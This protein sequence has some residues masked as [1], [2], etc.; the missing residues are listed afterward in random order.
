MTVLQSSQNFVRALKGPADPPVV[1]G[2]LKILLAEQAWCDS[3]FR[4]PNKAEVIADWLLTKFLKDKPAELKDHAIANPRYWKLL[5]S[6]IE[7]NPTNPTGTWLRAL[8]GRISIV[9]IVSNFLSCLLIADDP[10]SLLS[11]ATSCWEVIWPIGAQK[12][13]TDALLNCWLNYLSKT[14]TL[15]GRPAICGIGMILTDTYRHSL[16]NSSSKK[17]VYATLAQNQGNL[18]SWLEQVSAASTTSQGSQLAQS[19]FIAGIDTLFNLETLRQMQDAKEPRPQL[20]QTLH[21]LA[22]DHRQLVLDIL[23]RLFSHYVSALRK[24][25]G[26]IFSGGSS[27][28]ASGTQTIELNGAAMQFFGL[29]QDVL[30]Q[31]IR[32]ASTWNATCK[33]LEVVEQEHIYDSKDENKVSP[34]LTR[35]LELGL[36]GLSESCKA[37]RLDLTGA[38]VNCLTALARIDYDLIL[39]VTPRIL[40]RLLC[41]PTACAEHFAFLDLLLEYYV[42]T[43]TIN[44]Y[45]EM[46][47]EC[48]SL[49]LSP[50]PVDTHERYQLCLSSPLL[51]SSHLEKLS[52]VIH[53]FLTPGQCLKTSQHA[54][55]ALKTI[56]GQFKSAQKSHDSARGKGSRKKRK[57]DGMVVD[58]VTEEPDVLA[59]TFTLAS[60]LS[61]IVLS[62]MPFHSLHKEHEAEL[63]AE[64]ASFHEEFVKHHVAKLSKLLLKA[65]EE[66]Q[67]DGPKRKSKGSELDWGS[68]VVLTSLLR[69]LYALERIPSLDITR[70]L[71]VK[72]SKRL[73][74]LFDSASQNRFLPELSLEIARALL[75]HL[76]SIEGAAASE[77]IDSVLTYIEGRIDPSISWSGQGHELSKDEFG[78]AR[79][80]LALLHLVLERWLPTIDTLASS[81]QLSKLVK[82]IMQL[83][84]STN[85]RSSGDRNQNLLPEHLLLRTL[86]SAQI[87]ELPNIRTAFLGH[88]SQST[89]ELK[90]DG[91]STLDIKKLILTYQL[92]LFFPV[93]YL[94]KTCRAELVRGALAGDRVLEQAAF[95]KSKK[96]S[97]SSNSEVEGLTVLRLFVQRIFGFIGTIEQQSPGEISSF[98]L[99]LLKEPRV[100]AGSA[101]I[102]STLELAM[103]YFL[104]LL[105]Q[106]GKTA[107][108]DLPNVLSSYKQYDLYNGSQTIRAESFMRLVGVL[109][110]DFSFASFS[111]ENQEAFRDLHSHLVSG[112]EQ[113]I[114]KLLDGHEEAGSRAPALM[115]GWHATLSLGRWVGTDVVPSLFGQ[116]LARR[117]SH[118]ASK[119]QDD[120]AVMSVAI[121]LQELSYLDPS[122][123]NE[124]LELAVAVYLANSKII[125]E[126][127]RAQVDGF[128]GRTSRSLTPESYGHILEL[129]GKT[130]SYPQIGEST[131]SNLIH[132]AS[133][134]LREHP[135]NAL[136]I[137]QN[138]ATSFINVFNGNK[139]FFEGPV[140]LRLQVLGLLY[141]HFSERPAALRPLDMGGIWLLL[142]DFLSPSTIHD[143]ST[144]KDTF[145]KIVGIANSIIRLRRDLVGSVLPHLGMVLRQL[146]S[147]LRSIRPRLGSKQTELVM[148]TQPR[149]IA[150]GQPLGVDE[151]KALARLLET[152]NTKTV[153]RTH[154][155]VVEGQ[156][157]ESLANAFSKHAA[158]VLKA[159]IEALDEPLCILSLEV[160]KELAPGLY[161][162]CGMIS[163]HSRDAVMVSALDAAGKATMK[164]LWKEY[165]KQRYVGKG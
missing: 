101:Y 131:L 150:A 18:K 102:E 77:T 71:D 44:D 52:R 156:K 62:S 83:P 148:N 33:L 154:G 129:I 36:D 106:C 3:S 122:K 144:S 41:I 14:Q 161:A 96:N 130:L 140:E 65:S 119:A 17:K 151:A 141:Q 162:L 51:H 31:Q 2:P 114:I 160:R 46:V 61:Q 92:L 105:R 143:P 98:L 87:W 64:M 68:Q 79:A 113:E 115:S 104:E 124:Q 103:L 48:L 142:S 158:Y 123:Q 76:P 11:P 25:K 138:F 27:H 50:P 47:F 112:L 134:F 21:A 73:L 136:K 10:E 57:S 146:L 70:E 13:T 22:K 28:H 125:S 120:V 34:I 147:S 38:I 7:D 78:R 8:L 15:L 133:V 118:T 30:D 165:E 132:L 29:C 89:V 82:I 164:T 40:T 12:L 116:R 63:Q 159:Y 139:I 153:P 1:G 58:E 157:A 117:F 56:Q 16:S 23:P 99:H 95:G 74:Q 32:D 80:S 37:G 90:T 60:R 135:Q 9:P 108:G 84:V 81:E 69:L 19:V 111:D 126:T 35:S 91:S 97:N 86:R 59:V 4:V 93:E 39:P 155:G 75:F 72:N 5:K 42:K 145:H 67:S 20:F 55:E 109:T 43:R 45:V 88:L 26:T 127:G 107:S 100:A 110:K 137:T 128:V 49:K 163:E 6:V 121:I 66:D 94:T 152:L 24:H 54:C 85:A 149:W 53:Q